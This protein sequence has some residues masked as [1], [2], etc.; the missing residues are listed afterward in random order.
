[1]NTRQRKTL[2]HLFERPERSDIRW[3]E[4]ESMLRALGAEITEGQGSRVRISLKGE[5]ADLHRPHPKPVLKKWTVRF[6]RG[7]LSSLGVRP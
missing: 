5:R 3:S 4:I 2:Q 1:M 6:L 7:W